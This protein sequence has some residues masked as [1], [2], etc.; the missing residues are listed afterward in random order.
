MGSKIN[1]DLTPYL[2]EQSIPIKGNILISEATYSTS[3]R[4]M[5]RNMALADREDLLTIIKEA[6]LNERR[7]LLPVFAFSK[8]QTIATFLY[9]NLKGNQHGN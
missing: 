8:A 5:S 2:T 4:A 9:D 6:M 3:D 1:R 7:V